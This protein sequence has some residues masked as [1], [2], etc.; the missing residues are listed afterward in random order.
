MTSDDI[1]VM[2]ERLTRDIDQLRSNCE[3]Y[4][5]ERGWRKYSRADPVPEQCVG[6]WLDPVSRANMTLTMALQTELAREDG[7]PFRTEVL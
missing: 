2:H 5:T 4:L 7:S 1:R 6:R 3:Q